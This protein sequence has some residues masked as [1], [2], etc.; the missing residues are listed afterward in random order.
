MQS[1]SVD[2]VQAGKTFGSHI[3][4]APIDM[5]IRQGEFMTLLG[6]SGCGKSTLLNM[7]AGFVTPSSGAIRM[8]GADVTRLPPYRRK[9][10]M[11]FQNYALFPHMTVADNLAY[12]LKM[13]KLPKAEI[14]AQ[15]ARTLEVIKLTKFADRH[16][17]QLS[18]GQ[19]QR[20]AIGRAV[21][22]NPQVLLLDEPLSALDK[23]LRGS[24]QVEIKEIQQRLGITTV[25]VTHDQAEALSMSDRIAVM[26]EGRVRQVGTPDEVYERP[27]DGFVASFLGD[28]TRIFGRLTEI[29]G[30]A[31]V[32]LTEAGPLRL[33]EAQ[34]DLVLGQDCEVFI[35]PEHLTLVPDG[36]PAMLRGTVAMRIYQ[37]GHF[38][39]LVDHP[40]AVGGH[41]LLR[42]TDREQAAQAEPGRQIG[43]H[44]D[45]KN[46]RAF[47][48]A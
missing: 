47:P 1:A 23:N 29:R 26:S 30:G 13:Q 11:V 4:L 19:Q 38:D 20:V 15:V 34:A 35:R 6:P 9:I 10:G 31:A 48:S 21:I 37:G 43:L 5:E 24:M 3:A 12:G 14:R 41:I 27:S 44:C 17:R 46:L 8:A 32:I 39:I 2:I 33:P 42:L 22:T 45:P 16:P 18:G 7:I 28:V 40:G 36:Q 25:F